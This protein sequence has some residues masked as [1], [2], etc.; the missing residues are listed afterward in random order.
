MSR[1]M[2]KSSYNSKAEMSGK[3][4]KRMISGRCQKPTMIMIPSN[5]NMDNY[6]TIE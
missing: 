4:R 5:R 2:E 1:I 6:G 3:E